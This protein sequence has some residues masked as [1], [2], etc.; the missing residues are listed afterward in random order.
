MILIDHFLISAYGSTLKKCNNMNNS[1]KNFE[2][3][4]SRYLQGDEYDT[5]IVLYFKEDCSYSEGF[6]NNYRSN[7]SYILNRE[8]NNKLTSEETLIIRKE[9]GIEIHLNSPIM[10]LDTFFSSPFD[11]NMEY[12]LSVDLSNLNTSLVTNM[13][14]MFYGCGSLKSIDFSN[15][16][17]SSVTNMGT[18]FYGCTS[19]KSIDLSKFVTSLV[20]HMGSMFFNCTSLELL[21]LSSFDTSS[22]TYMGTMFYACSS[23]K[24]INLSNFKTFSI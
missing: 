21:D 9:I 6:K 12:L 4:N 17:T 18:M 8:N 5:Y 3:N 23:L 22:V 14:S 11:A 13:G 20:A 24:V 2:C 7:I 16:D 15:I 1:V 19:L 10:R